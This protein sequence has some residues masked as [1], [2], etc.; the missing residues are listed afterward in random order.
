MLYGPNLLSHTLKLQPA[1]IPKIK[2]MSPLCSPGSYWSPSHW[3]SAYFGEAKVERKITV[4]SWGFGLTSNDWNSSRAPGLLWDHHISW[5][6]KLCMLPLS[7]TPC[8]LLGIHLNLYF[9]PGYFRK[10]AYLRFGSQV[11]NWCEVWSSNIYL[12]SRVNSATYWAIESWTLVTAWQH[13]WLNTLSALVPWQ[14]CGWDSQPFLIQSEMGK[15]CGA[16][17]AV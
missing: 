2:S 11:I 8:F 3:R 15:G 12:D 6:M 7:L 14:G 1:S 10:G 4:R 16:N 5:T 17:W 13:S 9:V